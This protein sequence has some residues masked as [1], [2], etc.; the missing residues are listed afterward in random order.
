MKKL[1]YYLLLLVS[2]TS[3]KTYDFEVS[4]KSGHISYES[5]VIVSN[6]TL[7]FNVP[8][9][10]N[11]LALTIDTIGQTVL[12]TR[13]ISL[14]ILK[15]DTSIRNNNNYS[16]SL[17]RKQSKEEIL[18]KALEFF[19]ESNFNKI[20]IKGNKISGI[21]NFTI[22]NKYRT[23]MNCKVYL[24]SYDGRFTYKITKFNIHI[25]SSDSKSLE[26]YDLDKQDRKK[27]ILKINELIG[28]LRNYLI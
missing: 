12:N 7:H 3:C 8:I 13:F 19:E 26:E 1:F 15:N 11:S 28:N 5:S 6:D 9:T 27:I 2:I 22:N 25:K 23:K 17:I 21:Y 24:H 20:S 18:Q 10:N 14:S 16:F 4:N